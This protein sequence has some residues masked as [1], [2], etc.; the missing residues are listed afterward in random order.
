MTPEDSMSQLNFS[1]IPAFFDIADS[2]LAGGQ[3]LTD[4]AIL[5]ISHNAKFAAVHT[6]V[7]FMGYYQSGDTVPVPMSSVD[8]YTYSRAECMYVPVLV[9]S[10]SPA[11]GF[12]SGQTTFP[13]LASDDPGQG[14]L[15]MVPYQLDINDATGAV[16]CQ[17][18]WSTSGPENQGVVKVYCIAARSSVNVGG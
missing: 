13:A 8:G 9:S 2:V 5:K 12:V 4:D 7:I 6:E 15:I 1:T 16:T 10:R 3:P 14:S 11:A 17:T 18:Y